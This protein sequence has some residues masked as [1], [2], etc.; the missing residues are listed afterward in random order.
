MNYTI[1]TGASAGIGEVFAKQ[2]A[3]QGNN[4]ILVA[5]R[6]DKLDQLASKLSSQYSIQVETIAADLATMESSQEIEKHVQEK[7]WAIQGLINN[8][9]FGD[10]GSFLDI[11]LDR[12]LQMIQL[13]VTT[14]INLTY[15]LLPNIKKQI[16][17]AIS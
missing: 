13:N 2:L 3:Q 12:Q 16:N 7:G 10:R 6:K 8:A 9:G 1:I 15:R 5:R 17:K 14:L 4:L 11:S